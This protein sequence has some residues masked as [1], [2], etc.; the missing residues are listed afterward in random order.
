[1][2]ATED[3]FVTLSLKKKDLYL[4]AFEGFLIFGKV[5]KRQYET[6]SFIFYS[7]EL[8][9]LYEMIVNIV[10]F[11]A[12]KNLTSSSQKLVKNNGTL[13]YTWC[14]KNIL[15]N[16][17]TTKIVVLQ[18]INEQQQQI[19]ELIFQITDINILVKC[20]AMSFLSTLNMKNEQKFIFL[21]IIKQEFDTIKN[22]KENQNMFLEFMKKQG[23]LFK[24]DFEL[25]Q[26][27]V[28]YFDEVDILSK[29]YLLF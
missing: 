1:M 21:I 15:E 20:I 14:G 9:D 22:M 19:Y 7:Y 10:T 23:Q 27:F 29:L 13:C 24:Q 12:S 28:Y 6:E 11:F 25:Y 18:A 4:S 3:S 2:Y 5:K 8:K 26:L 16:G 17:Q